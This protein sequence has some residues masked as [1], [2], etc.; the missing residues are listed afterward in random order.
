MRPL[1]AAVERKRA[2]GI[3]Q[4][5]RERGCTNRQV[6]YLCQRYYDNQVPVDR[7]LNCR[8]LGNKGRIAAIPV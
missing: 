8:G 4:E 7:G 3:D 5:A 6:L 2:D 1:D